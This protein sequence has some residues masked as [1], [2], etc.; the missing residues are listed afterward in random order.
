MKKRTLIAVCIVYLAVLLRITVFRSSFSFAN[1]LQK[2]TLNLTLFAEYIPLMQKRRWF[3][4]LYLFVGN[5]IWFVP[6]GVLCCCKE[7][8]IKT[9]KI[10]LWGFL[11]SFFIESMQFIFGTGV[12]ELD[13]LILNTLGVWIGVI[14][15]KILKKGK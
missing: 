6:F 4:F 2:G 5:I 11:L 8:P 7:R 10:L 12:S 14:I 15:M 9:W 13:D 1:F 3:R